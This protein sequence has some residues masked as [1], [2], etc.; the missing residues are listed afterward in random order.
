M[1][2]SDDEWE[3]AAR[4]YQEYMA[5]LTDVVRAEIVAGRKVADLTE[6]APSDGVYAFDV[7]FHLNGYLQ[8]HPRGRVF[9]PAPPFMLSVTPVTVRV[10]DVAFIET[11]RLVARGGGAGVCPIVPDLIA[12]IISHPARWDEIDERVAD[13]MA[14]G[15][16]TAWILDTMEKRLIVRSAQG[17]ARAFDYNAKVYSAPLLPRLNVRV[18]E[19]LGE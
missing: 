3:E 7:A 11:H 1:N 19:L 16:S 18:Y 6:R 12:E 2:F 13:F 5:R 4:G 14:A 17:R 8:D 10:P 15:T 9:R